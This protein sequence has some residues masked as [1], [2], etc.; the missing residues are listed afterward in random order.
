MNKNIVYVMFSGKLH[1]CFACQISITSSN[2][3]SMKP[4]DINKAVVALIELLKKLKGA[5]CITKYLIPD[6]PTNYN[7]G[8][9]S[10]IIQGNIHFY[11]TSG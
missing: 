4:D 11:T 7:A 9:P 5:Q 1:H 2:K 3:T 6:I 10:D 8:T